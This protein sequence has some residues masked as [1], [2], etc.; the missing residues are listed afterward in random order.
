M[1]SLNDIDLPPPGQSIGADIFRQ[2]RLGQ[3]SREEYLTANASLVAQE[4]D[5]EKPRVYSPIP[6]SMRSYAMGRIAGTTPLDDSMSKRMGDWLHSNYQALDHNQYM[7]D[8]FNWALALVSRVKLERAA[9]M[10][11]HAIGRFEAMRFP[12][13]DYLSASEAQKIDSR[14]RERAKRGSRD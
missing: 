11:K 13:Q 3:I 4:S 6:Q 2:Y 12:S 10:L 7:I 9:G 14:E 8:H 1:R 5:K